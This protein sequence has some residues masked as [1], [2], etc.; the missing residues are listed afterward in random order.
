M[1]TRTRL[2]RGLPCS[3]ARS[4]VCATGEVLWERESLVGSQMYERGVQACVMRALPCPLNLACMALPTLG[5]LSTDACAH[6]ISLVLMQLLLSLQVQAAM[7]HH[8]PA[9]E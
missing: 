6:T 8:L 4:A 1:A 7:S 2:V 5:I 9:L 3:T